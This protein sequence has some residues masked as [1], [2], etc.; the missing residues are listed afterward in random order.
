[1]SLN[2]DQ[3]GEWTQLK[4]WELTLLRIQHRIM[5]QGNGN[6]TVLLSTTS[7][8]SSFEYAITK[9]DLE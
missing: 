2:T 7:E 1:M 8:C 6:T 4:S 3:P 9:Q 5:R